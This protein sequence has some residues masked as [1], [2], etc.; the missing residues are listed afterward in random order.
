MV[1]H[2]RLSE[3]GS[4]QV[5]QHGDWGYSARRRTAPFVRLIGEA[6]PWEVELSAFERVASSVARLARA[7]PAEGLTQ[8]LVNPQNNQR[9]SALAFVLA[10]L[11]HEVLTGRKSP[12][13]CACWASSG[14]VPMA[15][16]R[17]GGYKT[18]SVGR[19]TSPRRFRAGCGSPSYNFSNVSLTS[20]LAIPN[21]LRP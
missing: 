6:E 15:N 12:P 16:C 9:S 11:E 20:A 5:V 17:E 7:M 3:E 10:R 18:S 8:E 1:R 19:T 4:F 14:R 21:R 2:M 13:I